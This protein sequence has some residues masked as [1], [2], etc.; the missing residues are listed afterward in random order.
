MLKLL[1]EVY[2]RLAHLQTLPKTLTRCDLA[3]LVV[4]LVVLEPQLFGALFLVLLRCGATTSTDTGRGEIGARE[5]RRGGNPRV[6]TSTLGCG[7]GVYPVVYLLESIW[8]WE[9]PAPVIQPNKRARSQQP[10]LL[11]KTPPACSIH[12]AHLNTKINLN[13]HEAPINILPQR[14]HSSPT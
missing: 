12:C 10:A 14:S 9:T 6:V 7:G 3:G 13:T 5:L 1:A 11:L 4:L 8:P 2:L